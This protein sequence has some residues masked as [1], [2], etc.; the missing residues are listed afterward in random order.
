MAM[1]IDALRLPRCGVLLKRREL[2]WVREV[3]E[4]A[5][6]PFQLALEK[7]DD[8]VGRAR[9]AEQLGQIEQAELGAKIRGTDAETDVTQ[10]ARGV[11]QPL[12][13]DRK[14]TRLNSS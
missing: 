8:R 4:R 11:V 6:L 3:A 14:S 2:R 9:H 12:R 10:R 5:P 13:G 7:P 1:L